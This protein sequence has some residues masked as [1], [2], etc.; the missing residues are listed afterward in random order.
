M[1]TI[2]VSIIAIACIAVLFGVTFSESAPANTLERQ[3]PTVSVQEAI[4]Q[5]ERYI[6][7]NRIDVSAYFI[8]SVRYI[9]T[10]NWINSYIGKGPY[11]QVT[12]ELVKAADG[13]QHFI[14]IYMDGKIGRFG[15]Q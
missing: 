2:I 15:G 1:K 14:L 3:R 10:G 11:W 6:A 8:S 9:E 5:A 13:G 4:R 7:E 12:Y